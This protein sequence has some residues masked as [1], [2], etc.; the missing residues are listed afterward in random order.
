MP[1]LRP[2]QNPVSGNKRNIRFYLVSTRPGTNFAEAPRVTETLDLLEEIPVKR[3]LPLLVLLFFSVSCTPS[4]EEIIQDFLN[5]DYESNSYECYHGNARLP[6]GTHPEYLV[7]SW[8]CEETQTLEFYS[9][10]RLR[11]LPSSDI[12]GDYLEYWYDCGNHPGTGFVTAGLSGRWIVDGTGRLCATLHN[13]QAGIYFCYEIAHES[14]VLT[15]PGHADYYE[16][17]NYL[18]REYSDYG[19]ETCTLEEE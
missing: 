12:I 5:Y 16:N 9:D 17:G 7:G 15:F 19:T 8:E 10:G 13:V 14:G 1:G 4:A 18:G 3:F 2:I 6:S 11:F